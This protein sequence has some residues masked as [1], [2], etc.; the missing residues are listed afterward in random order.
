MYS[1]KFNELFSVCTR[2]NICG[3]DIQERM[4]ELRISLYNQSTSFCY[5]D[6]ISKIDLLPVQTPVCI[7]GGWLDTHPVIPQIE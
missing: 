2:M 1:D 6:L 5:P 4:Y 7:G 3:Q